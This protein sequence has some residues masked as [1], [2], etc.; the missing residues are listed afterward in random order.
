[1]DRALLLCPCGFPLTIRTRNFKTDILSTKSVR[2]K[3]W[4]LVH[5]TG[6]GFMVTP[7]L[8]SSQGANIGHVANAPCSRGATNN[9]N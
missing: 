5:T 8:D 9:T 2:N 3:T 4:L 6:C 1:M 7:A